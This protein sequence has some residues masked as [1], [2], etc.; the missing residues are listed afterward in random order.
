[1]ASDKKQVLELIEEFLE[2]PIEKSERPA[3]ADIKNALETLADYDLPEDV[4]DAVKVI[5]KVAIIEKP[6]KIQKHAEDDQWPSFVL[7]VPAHILAKMEAEAGEDEDE[8]DDD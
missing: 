7:P 2:E 1:M 5:L 8:D 6:K 3:L 4:G